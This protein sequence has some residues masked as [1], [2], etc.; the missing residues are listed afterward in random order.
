VLECVVNVSEG[1]DLE[2]LRTLAAAAGGSLVD[3]HFDIDHHRSVFTLA[4][5]GNLGSVEAARALAVAVAHDVTITDHAGEHPRFGALDV[6]P[7]V[8]LGGTRAEREQAADEARTFGQWW[9]ETFEVPVFLYDDASPQHRDLPHARTHGFRSR[10]P[11]FGPSEPHPLLGATA[12]GARKPLIAVNCVLISREVSDARRIA[13]TMRE[14]AG[15]PNGLPGVRALGFFLND[16]QRAQ[17][18]MNLVDLD[19]TGLQD[20]CIHVREL[21]KKLGTDVAKVEL[22]GLLPRRELDRCT[23]DFLEWSGIDAE[24]TIE[25]RVGQGPRWLPDDE[26]TS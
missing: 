6:V 15:P 20:A 21:A 11:D 26:K 5:P 18:S 17:V 19:R 16:I 2:K 10:K 14:A 8:A 7:F 22:V 4:G 1:R 24:D 23:D 12:V 3:V 9:A 25:A 13:R